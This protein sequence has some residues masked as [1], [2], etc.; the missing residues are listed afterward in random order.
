MD[1]FIVNLLIIIKVW[2]NENIYHERTGYPVNVRNRVF[3]KYSLPTI[4]LLPKFPM[5]SLLSFAIVVTKYSQLLESI[6]SIS[7]NL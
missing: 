7:L 1:M 4:L 2:T 3:Y 6:G 5:S